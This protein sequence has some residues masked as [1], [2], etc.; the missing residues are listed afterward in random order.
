MLGAFKSGIFYF[1]K[2][3]GCFA[4]IG[5]SQ[6]SAMEKNIKFIQIVRYF[7]ENLAIFVKLDRK[8][9]SVAR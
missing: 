8:A 2:K 4:R 5:F 7:G 6:L 1:D 9:L 3:I